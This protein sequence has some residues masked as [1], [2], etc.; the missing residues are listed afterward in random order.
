VKRIL[1]VLTVG[2]VMVTMLLVLAM[3]AL[4]KVPPFTYRA[5]DEHACDAAPGQAAPVTPPLSTAC[6]VDTGPR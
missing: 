1:L 2:I 6:L 5:I 3:P 4:A